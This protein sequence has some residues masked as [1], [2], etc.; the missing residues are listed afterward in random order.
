MYKWQH[1]YIHVT[2]RPSYRD[3]SHLKIIQ[4][5]LAHSASS[6]VVTEYITLLSSSSMQLVSFIGQEAARN[7]SDKMNFWAEKENIDYPSTCGH[8]GMGDCFSFICETVCLHC[9]AQ[10]EEGRT[11]S[12]K[13][14]WNFTSFLLRPTWLYDSYTCVIFIYCS[15]KTT[16]S[17]QGALTR[18]VRTGRS[19]GGGR[20]GS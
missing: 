20:G 16:I 7:K 19:G 10:W 17:W 8:W 12:L 11:M 2:D 1:A 15:I 5:S 18:G 3:A 4:Y 9:G 6:R 14:L 13:S